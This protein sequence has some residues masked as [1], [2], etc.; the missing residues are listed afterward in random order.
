VV[1]SREDLERA[2]QII[3]EY[4]LIDR[5]HVYFS[6]VFGKIEPEQIVNYMVEHRLNG[7]RIQIQIH[8]VIWDPNRR[9]V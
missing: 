2:D 3:Q 1:G 7:V 6:P 8:K 5:C 4:G 9:G